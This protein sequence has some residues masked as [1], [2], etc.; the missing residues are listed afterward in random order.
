MLYQAVSL[1]LKMAATLNS[2][3]HF[4]AS[5]LQCIK[6]STLYVDL[7]GFLSPCILTGDL[8]CP[9]LL[10]CIGTATIYI[11]ELTVGFETNITTNA[12]RKR[13]KYLQLTRDLSSKYRNAKF[14]N[15]SI[16][17]I[18]IFGKSCKSFI[19]MCND[20]GIEKQHLNYILSKITAIIIRSTYYIFCMRNKSWTNP[21]LLTY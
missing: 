21:D 2:A 17:S 13:N 19:K 14:I 20:L 9:D 3:L 1:L 10:L 8:L 4:V 11:V 5:T 15:L 16:S 7:P 6:N 12:Y 18:G